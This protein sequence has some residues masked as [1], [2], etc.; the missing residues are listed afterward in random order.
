MRQRTRT[1]LT[2]VVGLALVSNTSFAGGGVTAVQFGDLTI[3]NA[4]GLASAVTARSQPE[5]GFRR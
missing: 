5:S 1:T 2:W 3:D 4:I